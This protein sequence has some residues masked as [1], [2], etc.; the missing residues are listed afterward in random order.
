[1]IASVSVGTTAVEVLAAP[2][3]KPYQFVAISNNGS[4]AVYLKV[5]AGGDEV[6]SSNGIPLAPGAAFVVDQDAQ[7]R[8]MKAGVRAIAA[9]GTVTVGVQAF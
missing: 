9:S 7:T 4:Q 3:G 8:L 1:M 2:A 6:T 5:V